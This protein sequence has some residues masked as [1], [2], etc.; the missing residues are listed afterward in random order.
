MHFKKQR[1]YNMDLSAKNTNFF[2]HFFYNTFICFAFCVALSACGKGKTFE[3]YNGLPA[4]TWKQENVCKYTFNLAE[5]PKNP[6]KMGIGLRVVPS[7]AHKA[8]HVQLTIKSKNGKEQ[9]FSKKFEIQIKDENDKIKG[10]VMGDLADVEQTLEAFPFKDKGEYEVE[11]QHL[12]AS[13]QD[14][15]ILG[16]MEVGFFVME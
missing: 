2:K 10:G 5:P 8:I 13:T 16:V 12:N 1:S 4:L 6:L 11:I 14:Q 7:I 9:P 15:K 3:K